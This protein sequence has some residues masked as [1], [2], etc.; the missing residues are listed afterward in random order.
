MVKVSA[1]GKVIL[2]GEHAVVYGYPAI[3]A[4]VDKR[5]SIELDK[6]G[7]RV[8]PISLPKSGLLKYALKRTIGLT[9]I[10]PGA[11]RIKIDSRLP[12]GSGMGSSAALSVALVGAFYKL[13]RLPWDLKKI[14]E[15]GYEIEKKQDF[16]GIEKK[17]K[18]SKSSF[19][20]N[21]KGDWGESFW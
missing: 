2:S 5:I 6:A 8:K 16:C 7:K 19:R 20:L 10:N 1:P 18:I 4:A 17:L 15:I 9:G 3:L 11:L 13:T 21:L 14:N 12:I